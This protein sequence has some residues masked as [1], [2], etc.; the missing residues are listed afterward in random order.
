MKQRIKDLAKAYK[1]EMIDIRRHFHQYPELSTEEFETSAFIGQKLQEYGIAFKTGYSTT[2]I[3]A[4]IYGKNP[5]KKCIALR[6]DMDALPLTE[7]TNLPFASQN[8]GVMHACG[9]DFH[10]ASLLGVARILQETRQEWEGCIKLIFQPSE[11]DFRA[12]AKVMIAQGALENP[13]PSAIYAIH[14]L[15]EMPC[16][17]VGFKEGK[18]MASTDE[19]YLTVQ[20]K[21][22]HGA[23]PELNVDTVLMSAYILTALQQIVSRQAPPY[24]PTVLS[25][26]RIIGEGRTNINPAE[27]FIEGTLRTFDETWRAQAHEKIKCTVQHTAQAMGGNCK[28]F[29]DHGYPFVY[30]NPGLTRQARHWAEEFLSP[31]QV[32]ELEFRMTAED[33]SYFAQEIPAC[34]FRVGTGK[35]HNLHTSTFDVEED[36]LE[37][38]MGLMAYFSISGLSI[39][40]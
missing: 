9:H 19:I 29:I 25:F 8:P 12:G 11:E 13:R 15:P 6:A 39:N 33:F 31:S 24:I 37:I 5:D 27:V 32:Q 28:I 3:V 21:A 38:S 40:E 17:Q 22:G 1:A 30:N 23:T 34:F 7:D 4:H 26:G 18:Y 35:G 10:L 36:A 16:G 14:V 2:G 20:G